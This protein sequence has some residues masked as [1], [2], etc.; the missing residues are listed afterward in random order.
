MKL[1]TYLLRLPEKVAQLWLSKVEQ[2]TVKMPY[3]LA[4]VFIGLSALDLV[5][6]LQSNSCT[7]YIEALAWAFIVF[8]YLI[9]EVCARKL[10]DL[11]KKNE[12]QAA[13]K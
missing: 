8:G 5:K 11:K 10:M 2:R 12:K 13:H 6:A 7:Y 9:N 4:W 1:F 3:S